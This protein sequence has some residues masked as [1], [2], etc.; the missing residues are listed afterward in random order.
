LICCSSQATHSGKT[1]YR[2]SFKSLTR[3]YL[4]LR[5]EIADLDAMIARNSNGQTG[6]AQLLLTAGDNP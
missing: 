1:A 2:I 6:A 3:Q 4:E 5:D